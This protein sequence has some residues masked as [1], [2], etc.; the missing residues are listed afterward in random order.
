MD[1]NLLYIK[2]KYKKKY[3]KKNNKIFFS[4]SKILNPSC[5]LV[6]IYTYQI[7]P[8]LLVAI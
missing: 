1:F 8:Q 2:K 4:V 7:L 5:L 3:K 6:A